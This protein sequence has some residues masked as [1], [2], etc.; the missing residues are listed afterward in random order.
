MVYQA[1]IYGVITS[2]VLKKDKVQRGLFPNKNTCKVKTILDT[3]GKEGVIT[4]LK[5]YDLDE[6]I[7]KEY[8]IHPK[9]KEVTEEQEVVVLYRTREYGPFEEV[10][11]TNSDLNVDDESQTQYEFTQDYTDQEEYVETDSWKESVL[12][13]PEDDP[14]DSIYPYLSMWGDPFDNSTRDNS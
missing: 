5:Y 2:H 13:D 4:L 3:Y 8:H 7:L 10:V 1:L 6:T 9:K 12:Y 14:V 11:E